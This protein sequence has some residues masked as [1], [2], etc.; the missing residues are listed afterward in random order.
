MKMRHHLSL[1]SRALEQ[2]LVKY[3]GLWAVVKYAPLLW[4]MAA[5]WA[6]MIRARPSPY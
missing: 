2:G 1:F 4:L 6:L 5:V 3:I